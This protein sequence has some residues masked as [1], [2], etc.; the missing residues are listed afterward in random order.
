M[1]NDLYRRAPF[2]VSPGYVMDVVQNTDFKKYLGAMT[3]LGGI[4][5]NAFYL[6]TIK[7]LSTPSTVGMQWGGSDVV[8][9]DNGQMGFFHYAIRTRY[10]FTD[11]EAD[12]FA[13]LTG[14]S[15]QK[16]SEQ[17][18]EMAINQRLHRF[19]LFPADPSETSQG[20][21]SNGTAGTFPEDSDGHT[22]VKSYN[23]NELV[24]VLAE[25]ARDA[26]DATY[27]TAKPVVLASS[28][29]FINYIKTAIVPLLSM[30]MPGA[31]TYTVS[32]AY[33]DIIGRALGVGPITLVADDLL[34]GTA[35]GG[36]DY[37]LFIAPGLDEGDPVPE[38]ISQYA[39][40]PQ[41]IKHNTFMNSPGGLRK[42][43][44]PKKAWTNRG[45]YEIITTC[46]ACIRS[47]AVQILEATYE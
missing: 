10:E 30:Q 39:V 2:A 25:T 4:S 26:M 21:I 44:D 24:Q 1:L 46:G 31:G 29:R 11:H 40:D 12:K 18:S 8:G 14:A 13:A 7:K 33:S 43:I 27:G 34:K 16:L 37:V 6:N 42:T 20:I 47:E 19:S 5:D 22:T 9:A 3:K 38:D 23:V 17:L 41:N 28:V 15:L 45:N 32:G 35:T 36:K